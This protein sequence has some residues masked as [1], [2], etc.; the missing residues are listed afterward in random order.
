MKLYG[1]RKVV[2]A[3]SIGLVT[4]CGA[5]LA[6]GQDYDRQYR[7]WQRA[8][9]EAQRQYENYQRSNNSRDY[10]RWQQ[11][12][13]EARRLQ[14]AYNR[15]HGDRNYGY[16]TNGMYRINRNGSYY[17]TNARGVELLRTA[18]RNGYSQG[19]QQGMLDRRYARGYNYDGNRIYS[20][21]TYG[22]QSYVAQD[23]Y[24]YYFQQGFQRGYED[25]F[26]NTYRYGTRSGNTFTVLGSVIGSIL[27]LATHN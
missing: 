27:D 22:Y 9:A 1:I 15:S 4:L 7:D 16:T 23:Q 2:L 3:A 26:N 21:G 6:S 17:E 25:G 19:Y 18:I 12:Q 24:Q 20:E 11:A 8:Q 5:G 13:A 14:L 10:R